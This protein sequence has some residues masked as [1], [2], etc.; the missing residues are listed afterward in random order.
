MYPS[1]AIVSIETI[2]PERYTGGMKLALSFVSI[3]S[4][5]FLACSVSAATVTI[6]L[7]TT[8]Q[9]PAHDTVYVVID[10]S[11]D[12]QSGSVPMK[13]IAKKQYTAT[14]ENVNTGAT[15]QYVFS[16][17]DLGTP[18]YERFTPDNPSRLRKLKVAD[19]SASV[20]HTVQRWRWWQKKL[21]QG[22]ISLKAW[23]VAERD[24]FYLGM[25]LIDYHWDQFNRLITPTMKAI[26]KSGFEY[27]NVA[28]N[29]WMITSADPLMT[30]A[31]TVNTPTKKE[32]KRLVQAARTHQ[33]EPVLFVNFN[34]DPSAAG[35]DDALYGVEH[36]NAYLLDYVAK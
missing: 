33:I 29:P 32:L 3:G 4:F 10:P 30:T 35:I 25:G 26:R 31:E 6:D 2:S 15:I 12:Y 7:R 9:L 36:D 5:I 13:R 19:E 24:S 11:S 34:V 20:T 17:N 8:R 28:Y 23:D 16:R 14:L 27:V 21:K 1:V 22:K 18:S